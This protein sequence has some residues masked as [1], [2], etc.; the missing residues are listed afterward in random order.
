MLLLPRKGI[1]AIVAVIDIAL[2]AKGRPVAAKAVANRHRLPPRH[3]EP[4]LQALVRE[5][6]LLGVR[7]PRGGYEL[8]KEQTR[9]SAN[10]VL[11]AAGTVDA[12]VEPGPGGSPL[13][14]QVVPRL[15]QAERAYSASLARISIAE[16]SRSAEGTRK[17]AE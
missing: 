15:E 14:T 2:H 8:A 1:L 12:E 4:I 9:I 11:G 3:L 16:L 13:L 17:A 10:D 6:I 7:G 5:G